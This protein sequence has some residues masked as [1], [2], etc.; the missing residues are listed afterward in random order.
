MSTAKDRWSEPP[1][2]NHPHPRPRPRAEKPG[3]AAREL[4]ADPTLPTSCTDRYGNAKKRWPNETS[5]SFVSEQAFH[6]R[7]VA[8]GVYACGGCGG[9]HTT[10]RADRP[11]A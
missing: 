3:Q 8:M 11:A 5:A 4:R 1:R 2:R 10:C 9:W 6:K 7:G